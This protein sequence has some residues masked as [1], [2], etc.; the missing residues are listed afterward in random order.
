MVQARAG[1]EAQYRG[2][3]NALTTIAKNESLIAL[4]TG[5]PPYL[6]AKGTLTVMLF[7]FKEQFTNFA[8]WALDGGLTEYMKHFMSTLSK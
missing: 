5:F 6:L 7:L 2:T 1:K 3:W 4:W 8:R